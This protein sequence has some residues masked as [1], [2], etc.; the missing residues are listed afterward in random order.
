MKS[1]VNVAYESHCILGE[2]PIWCDIKQRI[3]FLD[4]LNPTLFIHTPETQQTEEVKLS[5]LASAVTLTSNPDVLL[6]ISDEGIYLFSLITKQVI[7]QLIKY[8]EKIGE[9]RPNEGAA[10]PDGNL[11]FGTM[12]YLEATEN[13]I[14]A[15][16]YVNSTSLSIK[17]IGQPTMLPNT[18]CWYKDKL[19]FVDSTKKR[20]F[21]SD[22]KMRDIEVLFD[23]NSGFIP[24]GSTVSTEG[25][26]FNAM[27]YGNAIGVYQ[28]PNA[29]AIDTIELPAQKPTSCCFGGKQMNTLYIT[30]ATED[31]DHPD[32]YQGNLLAVQVEDVGFPCNRFHIHQ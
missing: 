24:D 12:P 3:Y 20:F 31:L 30:S 13:T 26:L 10:T 11:I 7:K 14:G 17:Q 1:I 27:C 6:L 15:W 2:S 16:Y 29:T 9:T 32:Q 5:F 8:P 28:L 25:R 19:Y 21:V 22:K 23:D 18:L 4:I